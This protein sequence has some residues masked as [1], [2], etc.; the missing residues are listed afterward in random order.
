LFVAGEVWHGCLHEK[1]AGPGDQVA[2]NDGRDGQQGLLDLGR[3]LRRLP[4]DLQPDEDGQAEPGPHPADL[5]A[6]PGDDAAG[7]ERLHAAQAGRRRQRDGIR[8][9]DVCDAA[10]LLEPRY[11]GTIHSVWEMLRHVI[12]LRTLIAQYHCAE[13][14][15]RRHIC[16]RV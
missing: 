8:E 3:G 11:D 12:K 2:G 6:V 4:L 10:V 7:L 16:H 9:V 5:R 13:A 14:P 1:V 15:Y